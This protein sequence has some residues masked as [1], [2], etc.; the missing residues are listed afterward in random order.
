MARLTGALFSLAASGT[1]ADTLTFAKWKGIQYVR[2]RVVPANPNTVAQQEVRGCFST[3]N[4]LWKRM[5]VQARL[6]FQNAIRGLAL[7]PRNQHIKENV[8]ALIDDANLDDLVMSVA[9]GNAIVP[10]NATA[11]DGTNGRVACFC[12]APAAPPGYTISYMIGVAVRDGIPGDAI[13]PTCYEASDAAAP[14]AFDIFCLED[15][16]FQVAIIARWIRDADQRGF[17]SEAVRFQV[18]VSGTP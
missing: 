13:S 15:E 8:A 6:P 12:E 18:T 1:I 3:L 11:V 5:G 14:Y 2:T 9:G 17:V 7:T 16:D 4:N 10:I